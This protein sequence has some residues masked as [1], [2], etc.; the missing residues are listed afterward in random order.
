[1]P[2]FPRGRAARSAG[3][4][5]EIKYDGFRMMAQ[6]R[7]SA[8]RLFTRNG[9]DWTERYPALVAAMEAL[10][11]N[12]CLIDGEIAVCNDQG[13]AVF[14]RLRY[15]PRVNSRAAALWVRSDRARW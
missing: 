14:D 6:R 15:G 9:Y 3:W 12:S 1:M 10:K 2:A 7:G 4:I 8:V 13:L 11:L 5:H